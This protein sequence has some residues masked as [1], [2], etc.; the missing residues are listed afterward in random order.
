M[1]NKIYPC[2]WCNNNAKE[3]ADFYCSVFPDAKIATENKMVV[4]LQ[5]S[6]QNFMLLNG[7]DHFKPNPGISLMYMTSDT[8]LIDQI[9]EKLSPGGKV[10]MAK[11]KYPWSEN[12]VWFDDRFGVSWQLYLGTEEHYQQTIVPTLMFTQNM[13]GRANAAIHF[14]TQTF[15]DSKIQ[16]IKERANGEVEHADF[17]ILDYTLM[18]M[19]G[20]AGH[21]FTFNEG[22][23]L[24]VNCKDQQEI[25]KYWST[26][27]SNGGKE[28]QCGWLKDPYGVSWQIVPENLQRFFTTPETAQKVMTAVQKMKKLDIAE[29]EKAADLQ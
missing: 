1:K 8:C 2:I 25:D 19:D 23:S 9:Y 18:C 10:L 21:E 22:V 16:G 20:G 4:M 15:P 26:L 5:V 3:M 6:G 29:M 28:S 12:Y 7:G 11:N 17:K 27:T 14:Y 24:V 13:N